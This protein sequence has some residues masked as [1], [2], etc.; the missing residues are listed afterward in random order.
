M[1]AILKPAS[2]GVNNRDK[3]SFRLTLIKAAPFDGVVGM[4]LKQ[5]SKLGQISIF[6]NL[7]VR[8]ANIKINKIYALPLRYKLADPRAD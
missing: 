1:L 5:G 7:M 8:T 6:E 4:G 2:V 3:F